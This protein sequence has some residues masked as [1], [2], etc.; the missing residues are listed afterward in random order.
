MN[1]VSSGSTQ[2]HT[3]EDT[4]EAILNGI[5]D[6]LETRGYFHMANGRD[7]GLLLDDARRL[8][9]AFDFAAYLQRQRDWSGSTFGPG[10]RS[11]M[12]VDHI[13]KELVEIEAAPSDL[14]E[15]IDVVMLA[16]DG[17]WR[18]GATPSEIAT[19]LTT[20]LAVNEERI[21]PNWRT[22]DPNKAIEHVR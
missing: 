10:P 21:W 22:A 20:K 19:A 9:T 2:Q 6:A 18:S 14:A 15:W 1:S 3:A 17:A 4:P 16:L 13:R 5:R 8:E 11:Q 12:V 7:I